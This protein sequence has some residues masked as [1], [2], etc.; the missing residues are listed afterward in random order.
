M[1]WTAAQLGGLPPKRRAGRPGLDPKVVA[2][3]LR[4]DREGVLTQKRIA[5]RLGCTRDQVHYV[6]NKHHNARTV[7]L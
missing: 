4:L 6:V 3:I 5:E 7:T 2:E 1:S